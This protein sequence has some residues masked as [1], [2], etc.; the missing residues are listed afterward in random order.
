[1]AAKVRQGAMQPQ[2]NL[3][4]QILQAFPLAGEPGQHPENHGLV[5][6]DQL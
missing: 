1:M 3:L 6:L 5:T 2:K 4:R